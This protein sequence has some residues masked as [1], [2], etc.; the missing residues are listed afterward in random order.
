MLIG[1]AD[2]LNRPRERVGSCPQ[3][4]SLGVRLLTVIVHV[5]T[6]CD[7]EGLPVARLAAVRP[8]SATGHTPE[9]ASP[10]LVVDGSHLTPSTKGHPA[11]TARG[12]WSAFPRRPATI[13][14]PRTSVI[15]RK[16]LFSMP[17]FSRS[18]RPFCPAGATVPCRDSSS[19]SSAASSSAASSPTGLSVLQGYQG[20]AWRDSA[21]ARIRGV[22]ASGSAPPVRRGATGTV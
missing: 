7:T 15:A 3:D 18:W 10:R 5:V 22:S 6:I 17:W 20:T 13:Q 16:R 19:A 21:E 11:R 4:D 8:G 1:P 14:S 2:H 9:L 12:A